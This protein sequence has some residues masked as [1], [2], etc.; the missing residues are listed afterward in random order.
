MKNDMLAPILLVIAVFPFASRV[1]RITI[2]NCV[3]RGVV[4]ETAITSGVRS[5]TILGW[6]GVG[7]G[8]G[9]GSDR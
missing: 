9:G 6:V 2:H 7:V 3:M 4:H 8:G 5:M 1:P